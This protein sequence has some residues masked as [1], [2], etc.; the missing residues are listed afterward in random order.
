[1]TETFRRSAMD[2]AIEAAFRIG[3][4]NALAELDGDLHP[5]RPRPSPSML[6]AVLGAGERDGQVARWALP[7]ERP[8]DYQGPRSRPERPRRWDTAG[9][10]RRGFRGLGPRRGAQPHRS[11]ASH[12]WDFLP[13]YIIYPRSRATRK[14]LC[15]FIILR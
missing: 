13:L 2:R 4:P 9:E 3:F 10:R 14:L 11:P 6:Y 5:V 1:M 15:A 7:L 12:S 8:A